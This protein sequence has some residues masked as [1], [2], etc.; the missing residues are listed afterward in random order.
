MEV[1]K[2]GLYF[3]MVFITFVLWVGERT[4]VGMWKSGRELAVV[5]RKVP[6]YDTH[7]LL[8]NV[9]LLLE[10]SLSRFTFTPFSHPVWLW[11]ETRET[12]A[13]LTAPWKGPDRPK[14]TGE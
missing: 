12:G 11:S 5:S 2:V 10:H 3:V 1:E 6:W 13:S 14:G 9:Y 7:V 8:G 4:K